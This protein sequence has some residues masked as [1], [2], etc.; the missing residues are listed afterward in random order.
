MLKTLL[1]GRTIPTRQLLRAIGY[2]YN[3]A[4]TIKIARR[5]YITL[6]ECT[7]RWQQNTGRQLRRADDYR[8]KT[9][10]AGSVSCAI[11]PLAKLT[12][13]EWSYIKSLSS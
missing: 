6:P 2:A 7:I 4:D 5:L 9:G 10:E 11:R 8:K 3:A 13:K 12:Q 1:L